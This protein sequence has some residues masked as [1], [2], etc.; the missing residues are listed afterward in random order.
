[1]SGVDP[2]PGDVPTTIE[3]IE[4]DALTTRRKMTPEVAR[5]RKEVLAARGAFEEDL[6]GLSDAT[7][8]ALD[9]P[10]KVRRNP[11]KSVALAGGAGFLLLGGPRRV[12]RAATARL[13][14]ER[15][16]PL[17]GLLPDEVERILRRSGVYTEPGVREALEADFADYLRDKG[18]RPEPPTARRSLWRTYDALVGPLGTVAARMLVERLFAAEHGRK[19]G[20]PSTEA[21][22]GSRSSRSD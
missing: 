17:D 6:D 15:R 3:R 22:P 14:P 8:S 12:L 4:H 5:A 20:R 11:V 7:R 16:D 21:S 13:F 19:S 9:I 10:A 18:R 1:M 2:R